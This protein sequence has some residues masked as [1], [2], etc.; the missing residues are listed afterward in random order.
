MS[1]ITDKNNPETPQYCNRCGYVF[2]GFENSLEKE[3]HSKNI[4]RKNSKAVEVAERNLRLLEDQ[5]N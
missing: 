2:Q 5:L 1:I 3:K 4:C